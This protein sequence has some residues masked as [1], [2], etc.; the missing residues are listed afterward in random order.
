M[1]A[2]QPLWPFAIPIALLSAL[3]IIAFIPSLVEKEW[4]A[5]AVSI[6]LMLT[7]PLA[8]YLVIRKRSI[9]KITVVPISI[10]CLLIGYQIVPENRHVILDGY[11]NFVLPFVEL[12]VL[13]FVIYN[14]IRFQKATKAKRNGDGDFFDAITAVTSEMAP[15]KLAPFLALEISM[16]YYAF[17]FKKGKTLDS[18]AFA[19]H[20]ESGVRAL[21]GAIVFIILVETVALHF[22]LV[23]W[24]P[25][26]AW[27]LTILS[28]YTGLQF[29][30]FAR[31]MGMR[32]MKIEN[33]TLEFRLGTFAQ[34]SIP[35]DKIAKAYKHTSDLPEDKSVRKLGLL[36]ELES[37]NVVLEFTEP[38]TFTRLYGKK[39]EHT[40]IA[41][42]IDNPSALL[43]RIG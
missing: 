26:F 35:L 34:G 33:N 3:F 32:P 10:I 28:L 25:T 30:A 4:V 22:L 40:K 1:T 11:Q 19:Y 7:V 6:D 15:G 17:S 24:S 41:F 21:Y 8:W 37:H 14:V 36:G 2:R 38:I 39:E 13:S 20:K 27:V 23:G 5:E 29:L 31:S 12:G 16:L 9:P 43:E 18:N 42:W